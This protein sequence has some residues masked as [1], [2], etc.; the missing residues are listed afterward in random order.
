MPGKDLSQRTA[1]AMSYAVRFRDS[2]ASDLLFVAL[3]F[4]TF[5]ALSATVG[6]WISI[7]FPKHMRFGKR[8]NVSGMAGILLI[9]LI[10]VLALPPLIATLV[11]YFTQSMLNEYLTLLGLALLSV[12]LYFAIINFH[13]RELERREI[14]ILEAVREPMD[15]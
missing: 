15:E 3:S 5:A 14:E 13:G 6:N 2:R 1:R 12:G 8:L 11:G 9:P 4:V 7:R 10:I